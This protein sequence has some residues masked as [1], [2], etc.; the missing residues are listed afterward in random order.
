MAELEAVTSRR[1]GRERSA[2]AVVVAPER[3]RQLPEDGAELRRPDERLDARV[4]AID[5]A[6]EIGQPLDVRQVSARL[7]GEDEVKRR[8]LDPAGDRAPARQAVERVVHLDRVEVL[9]VV[10]QP[11]TRGLALVELL[12]PRRVVPAGAAYADRA[13]KSCAHR[14]AVPAATTRE[15]PSTSSGAAPNGGASG[16]S[17]ASPCSRTRSWAAAMS[18]ERAGFSEQTASTRPAARWQSESAREPMIRSRCARPTTA[19]AFSATDA[20]RVASNARISIRSFGRSPSSRWPLRYA[21]SP[22]DAV[23]T[24][25]VPKSWTKPKSTSAIVGPLETAID[26]EKNPMPRFALSEP[27]IGSITKRASPPEPRRTSPRSSDT[28]TPSRLAASNL[29]MIPDSAAASI[30]VVSSP[31]SPVPTTGSRS[32]R[33]GSSASANRT[34]STAARQRSSQPSVKRVEEETRGELREEVRALLGHDVAATCYREDVVDARR[35]EQERRLRVPRVDGRD[36]LVAARRVRHALRCESIDELHV[37][38]FAVEELVSA[39]AVEDDARKLVTGC[40]DRRAA[41]PVDV[42]RDAMRRKDREPRLTRRHEHDHHPCARV[43]AVLVVE[44]ERGLVAMVSVGNEEL[45]VGDVG[46]AL[47]APEPVPSGGDVRCALRD[48]GARAVVQEEDRLELRARRPQEAQASLLWP[49]MRALVWQNGTAVVR[50]DAK[51]HDVAVARPLHAVRTDVRLR[52][53]PPRRV[54]VADEHAGITPLAQI[55]RR[56]LLALR[57]REMHDVVQAPR[58]VVAPIV[59]RDDVVRRCDECL[60]RSRSPLVVPQCPERP[61]L[62]HPNG[63]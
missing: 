37:E 43:G 11:Q 13:A 49:R 25:S 63:T 28:S 22:R 57:Q 33:V 20:V 36:S 54:A 61:D 12:A 7:D 15:R 53:R 27:S 46:T 5:T 60:Q 50:L 31:P 3:R 48:L 8:L 26:S 47:D 18:T 34:S 10:T 14:S 52:Q 58:K 39:G 6:A 24:S 42:L 29:R 45:Q 41:N 62:R 30:A 59:V 17:I 1:N 32:A 56:L 21:P 55:A 51:R 35:A 40:V 38:T 4:E 23:H 16:R 19:D 9:G 2:E 44:R